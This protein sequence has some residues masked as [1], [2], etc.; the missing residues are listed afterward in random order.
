MNSNEKVISN[1]IAISKNI[2]FLEIRFIH[3]KFIAY[4][5]SNEYLEYSIDLD[6]ITIKSGALKGTYAYF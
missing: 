6:Q 5:K 1:V 4:N 2:S 3:S